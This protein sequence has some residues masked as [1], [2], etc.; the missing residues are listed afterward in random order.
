[1]LDLSDIIA[2]A[3][4]APRQTTDVE[5]VFDAGI[6][7]ELDAIRDEQREA[8]A[9]LERVEADL[10]AELEVLATDARASDPRPGAAR[11]AAAKET[12]A[13][14]ARLDDIAGRLSA[15]EE[16]AAD[17]L[18]TFRFTAMLGFEWDAIT[19]ASPARDNNAEDARTGYNTDQ[20]TLTA[21]KRIGTRVG[22]DDTIIDVP[23]E[24]WDGIW[25]TLPADGRRRIKNAV[26]FLHEYTAQASRNEAVIAARKVLTAQQA[27][28]QPSPSDSESTPAGLQAGNRSPSSTSS[29]TKAA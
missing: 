19:A 7:D 2:K 3:E 1:M 15:A 14:Q 20:V 23:A 17:Y 27:A 18:V 25:R 11:K 28:T 29:T 12:D 22:A 16:R 26:W 10:G 8:S 24:Q 9:D 13:V 4:E 5:V 6:S 21:V